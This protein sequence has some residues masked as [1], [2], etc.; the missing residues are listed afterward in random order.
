MS[1]RRRSK[2]LLAATLA[3]LLFTNVARAEEAESVD[4][5]TSAAPLTPAEESEPS[6]S[7]APGETT[8]TTAPGAVSEPSLIDEVLAQLDAEQELLSSQIESYARNTDAFFGDD[9]AF[10]DNNE[11]H[12]QIS[13][14][15]FPKEAEGARFD[16]RVRVKL[17]LP[18][19]K[20]RLRLLIESDPKELGATGATTAP[21]PVEAAQEAS[22]A[23]A[24]ETQL[25]DTGKWSLS[26]AAGIRVSSWPPDPYVRVR[27]VRYESLDHWLVRF[28]TGASYYVVKG[29]IASAQLDFDRA[30]ISNVLFR[31]SSS[32]DWKKDLENGDTELTSASQQFTFFH[33]VSER[34]SLAYSVGVQGDDDPK[35][36]VD[37]YFAT[38]SYRQN[39]YKKWLYGTVSPELTFPRD[40]DFSATWGIMLRLEAFAGKRYR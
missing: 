25:K 39:L 20:K 21:T 40:R 23:L 12:G 34:I 22:Y 33:D 1:I 4:A 2:I 13:V 29:P 11:T 38:V 17:D 24:L 8:P 26:P 36:W 6:A 14:G 18:R 28:A 5:I 10:E 31:A 37:G 32:I 27:A 7:P 16:F 15:V 30:W 9:R 19:T 3:A 35:W